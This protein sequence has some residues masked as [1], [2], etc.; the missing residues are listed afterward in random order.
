MI[1]IISG[2]NRK[3]SNSLVIAELYKDVLLKLG[4]EAELLSLETLPDDFIFSAM[5]EKNGKNKPFN[6]IVHQ[7]KSS[8][9]F[10][11]VIPEYNGSFP[12]ILKAFID[13]MPYPS[14]LKHKKCMLIGL[15]S[16][17]S[18]GA[19]ALSHF[20]DILNYLNIHVL[21]MKVKLPHIE[22]LLVEGNLEDNFYLNLIQEQ[23]TQFINF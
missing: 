17:M 3:N 1:T 10:V 5:F 8:Q 18:G 13:G 23:A 20:T 6:E 14:I 7:I 4:Y 12:G 21:A 11:F 19:L 2:T 16:G 9:K 15:S 22:E